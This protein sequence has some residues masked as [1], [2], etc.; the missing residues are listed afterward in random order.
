MLTHLDLSGNKL[1]N[2]NGVDKLWA[3]KSLN[4]SKNNLCDLTVIESLV[5]LPDLIDLNIV[6]NS[7][8]SVTDNVNF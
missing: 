4:L 8:K 7:W 6:N 5:S 3:L 1:E 2:I